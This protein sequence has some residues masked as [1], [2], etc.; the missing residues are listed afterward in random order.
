MDVASELP[1]VER[2]GVWNV[3][4]ANEPRRWRL[5]RDDRP[6]VQ[7]SYHHE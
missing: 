5:G 6:Q 4:A 7:L 3:I 2:S 1:G